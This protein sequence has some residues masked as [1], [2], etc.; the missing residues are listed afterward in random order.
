M[1]LLGANGYIDQELGDGPELV[2][3]IK[4]DLCNTSSDHP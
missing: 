2:D 4:R 1:S 3:D